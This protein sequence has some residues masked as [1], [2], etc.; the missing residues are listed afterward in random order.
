MEAQHIRAVEL[1]L[2]AKD[3]TN[4]NGSSPDGRVVT[5]LLLAAVVVVALP[6]GA[7]ALIRR[8]DDR[9]ALRQELTAVLSLLDGTLALVGTGREIT[10]VPYNADPALAD[11]PGA[12]PGTAVGYDQCDSWRDHILPGWQAG[13]RFTITPRDAQ[14]GKAMLRAIERFWTDQGYEPTSYREAGRAGVAFR[15]DHAEVRFGM[16][17]TRREAALSGTT[18]CLPLRS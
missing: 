6:I 5:L 15:R 12:R 8:T 2:G 1:V 13:R 10:R 3:R 4:G 7:V 18:D 11:D 17:E 16:D 14:D 9:P